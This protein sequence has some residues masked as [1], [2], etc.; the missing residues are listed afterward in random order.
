M[1]DSVDPLW[2]RYE[3]SVQELL[4]AMDPSAQVVHNQKVRGRLSMA[5]RQV[6]VL[7]RGTVVGIEV[8]VAVECKRHRRILDIGAVDQ[9]IGKVLD[10]SADKGILYSYSGFT[11][12][13]VT[14]AI[15]ARNPHILTVAVET[16]EELTGLL[17]VPGYP[18]E[19]SWQEVPPQ[20]I[21]ELRS[22]AFERFLRT[23]EW[24]KFW[25]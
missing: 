3:I 20:W 15:N 2:Q 22:D 8:T 24:N 21:E 18:A 17:G 13:A 11:D 6:D 25:S 19:L 10:L 23:G 12:N 1:S 9:F 14:R 16:P 7:A 5:D 4:A